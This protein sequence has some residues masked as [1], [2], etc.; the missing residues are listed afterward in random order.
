MFCAKDKFFVL[1]IHL[2]FCLLTDMRYY[3]YLFI[4]AY[5]F[6]KSIV[7]LSEAVNNLLSSDIQEK[8]IRETF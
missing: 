7:I 3:V 1:D 5:K 2:F 6:F 8:T 4:P